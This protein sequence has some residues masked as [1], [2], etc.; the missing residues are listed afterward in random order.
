[1]A[2]I[3]HVEG[4]TDMSSTS[5]Y[6]GGA[7]PVAGDTLTFLRS[8]VS[9]AITNTTALAAVDL[10][11]LTVSPNFYAD[12]GTP[13]APIRVDVSNGS[14]PT[15]DFQG[16]SSSVYLQG[17]SGAAAF[18]IVK[19][20]P[21][22]SGRGTLQDVDVPRLEAF[23]GTLDFTGSASV[24][25]I[26]AM[27]TAQVVCRAHA[28]DTIGNTELGGTAQL[29]AYRRLGGTCLVPTGTTLIYD[30][31]SNTATGQV[32]LAGGRIIWKRGA[33]VVS[34]SQGIIDAS[35]LQASY[36]NASLTSLGEGVTI[37]RGPV[38]VTT[39][40][41]LGNGPSFR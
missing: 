32:T 35:G 8:G 26:Y 27:G 15:L 34:G 11:R 1:M 5:F 16:S 14:S 21:V 30:V 39:T 24:G 3:N 38:A 33:L 13:G 41:N 9:L 28:S 29:H 23:S 10:N 40:S 19:W 2:D 7:L 25:V 4:A 6:S 17:G 18:D 12:F 37:I 20:R 22:R 31:D 36:S